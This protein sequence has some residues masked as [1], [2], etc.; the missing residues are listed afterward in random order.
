LHRRIQALEAQVGALQEFNATVKRSKALTAAV[1]GIA[2]GKGDV[3]SLLE[4]RQFIMDTLN[5]DMYGH[6]V[7]REVR[8][9]A[10]RVLGID[11]KE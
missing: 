3:A 4:M 8:N 6:A 1:S 10:R 9:A 5:P 7:S 2:P 11:V